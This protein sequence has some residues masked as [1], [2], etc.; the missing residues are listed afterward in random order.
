MKHQ[1][2]TPEECRARRQHNLD[3]NCPICDGGLSQ[4]KVCG[5]AEVEL[6][7]TPECSGKSVKR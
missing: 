4:C 2:L 6:D 1:I 7:D 5:L 3:I